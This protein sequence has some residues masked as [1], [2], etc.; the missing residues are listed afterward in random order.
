M[1]LQEPAIPSSSPLKAPQARCQGGDISQIF[2]IIVKIKR[3]AHPPPGA[4]QVL[5]EQV[6]PHLPAGHQAGGP[7]VWTGQLHGRLLHLS[8]KPAVVRLCLLLAGFDCS[9]LHARRYL[10]KKISFVFSLKCLLI[11]LEYCVICQNHN[12]KDCCF[13]FSNLL[14]LKCSGIFCAYWA[15][16]ETKA[17]PGGCSDAWHVFTLALHHSHQ[18]CC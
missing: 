9:S 4:T 5:L 8:Q 11:C 16:T 3:R 1:S 10:L 7:E 15:E 2:P 18:R 17:P 6:P 12:F 13:Q 14:P